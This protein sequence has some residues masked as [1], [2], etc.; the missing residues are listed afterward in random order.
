MSKSKGALGAIGKIITYVLVVLLVLGVAGTVAY[1][2]LRAQG[3]TYYVEYDGERYVANGDGGD[4]IL[5]DGATYTFSVKSL[6]GEEVNYSV[7]VLSNEANNFSFSIGDELH[8]FYEGNDANDDYSSLFGLQKSADGFTIT[9]PNNVTVESIV[10][11]KFGSKIE[12]LS[13]LSDEYSYFVIVVSSGDSVVNLWFTLDG[14]VTGITLDTTHIIFG[15][16]SAASENPPSETL[17]EQEETFIRYMVQA[18]QAQSYEEVQP[19]MGTIHQLYTDIVMSDET[20]GSSDV[21]TALSA[22]VALFRAVEDREYT[23]E[24][25]ASVREDLGDLMER[26]EPME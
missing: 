12:L 2:A 16:N 4:I 14:N 22:Y 25:A 3:V 24:E 5:A 11:E 9:I 26:Y 17:P 18:A 7:K 21:R 1:F 8:R 19:I 13:E 20:S 15:G 23:A 10:S 6:T